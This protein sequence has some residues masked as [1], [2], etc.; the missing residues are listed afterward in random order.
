MKTEFE[1]KMEVK[2]VLLPELH[3]QFLTV[4]E[5]QLITLLRINAIKREKA[6][7][8]LQFALRHP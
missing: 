7:M 5:A 6:I 3:K 8:I 2:E 1:Q 4:E